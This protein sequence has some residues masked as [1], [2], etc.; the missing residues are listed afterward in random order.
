[1]CNSSW[2][3]SV[4]CIYRG[5]VEKYVSYKR[6]NTVVHTNRATQ[7]RQPLTCPPVF[8][9]PEPTLAFRRSN[10][11]DNMLSIMEKYADN[12]EDIVAERTNDLMKE[13]KKTEALLLRMLPRYRHAVSLFLWLDCYNSDPGW[14][15][16]CRSTPWRWSSVTLVFH[17]FLSTSQSSAA[18]YHWPMTIAVSLLT[19]MSNP[20]KI[21]HYLSFLITL[22]F[23]DIYIFCSR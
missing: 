17:V 9:W 16:A 22:Q 23:C 4:P 19:S 13:K 14:G 12:L 10:I 3:H 20:P 18:G 21:W 5:K 8:P 15:V 2:T 11:F 1:M 6:C 7:I